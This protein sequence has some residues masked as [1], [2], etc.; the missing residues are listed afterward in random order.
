MNAPDIRHAPDVLLKK[1]PP[2]RF[3]LF[4][5]GQLTVLKGEQ[6]ITLEPE[7]IRNLKRFMASFG[8]EAS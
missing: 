4:S 6:T 7:D 2:A 8:G 3:A 1:T 5:D